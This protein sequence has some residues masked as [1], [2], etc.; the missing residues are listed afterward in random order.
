MTRSLLFAM[1]TT[2]CASTAYVPY[3]L[4]PNELYLAQDGDLAIHDADGEVAHEP[5]W[6][7]LQERIGCVAEARRHARE[8]RR[9]GRIARGLAIA[10]GIL[11][12]ASLAALAGIPYV[13]SDPTKA[14]AIIGSGLGVGMIGIGLA[15]GS[16]HH[17]I[18]ANGNAVDAMNHH[19]DGL[20]DGRTRCR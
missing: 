1:L 12:V 5:N 2:G 4:H 14:G 8:A 19:N 7:G 20:L 6:N 18:V 17:R 9:H 11:G 16:R 13:K 15:G 10:G 3:R